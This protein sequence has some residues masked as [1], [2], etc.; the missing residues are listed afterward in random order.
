MKRILEVCC[1]SNQNSNTLNLYVITQYLKKTEGKPLNEDH[2][3]LSEK[4]L[5]FEIRNY[6]P[7]HSHA[8]ENGFLSNLWFWEDIEIIIKLGTTS[9]REERL[10]FV[11]QKLRMMN[12]R[13]P[14]T[15]YI[16]FKRSKFS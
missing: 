8:E 1:E 15:V 16:P 4:P 10:D 5:G 2:Q 12:E 14:A 11:K 6:Q 13:L 3:P 9:K 7:L